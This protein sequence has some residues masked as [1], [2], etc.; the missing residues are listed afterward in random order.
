MK[1]IGI[2]SGASSGLGAEFVKQIGNSS[3]CD[4]LYLIAR[5]A[6]KMSALVDDFKKQSL[7]EGR[8]FPE[9]K[10]LSMDLCV[11]K[12]VQALALELKKAMGYDEGASSAE[13]CNETNSNN[14]SNNTSDSSSNERK[15]SIEWLVN[16]A[17]FGKF[18]S[19]KEVGPMYASAMIDL[20]CK[21]LVNITE[22]CLP[23]M[24]KKGKIIEIASTASFFPLPYMNVYSAGKAFVLYY[25]RALR[26]E[27]KKSGVCLTVVTP[28]PVRTEFWGIGN[29][30]HS[31]DTLSRNDALWMA[32]AC[33]VV[34]K[35]IKDVRKNRAVSTYGFLN[36]AH[37]RASK[38]LPWAFLM[39][40]WEKFM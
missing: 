18:G 15:A 14:N 34:K 21:A 27:I 31:M 5:R 20:N 23:Y 28:G 33:D 39:R 8:T 30:T 3:D 32:D 12:D 26:R 24:S 38:V 40:F 4:M 6:D 13:G 2:I 11:E 25:T 7:L 36:K 10:F 9:C 29:Q 22:M 19:W 1:K 17:G 37:K 16:A 35:A